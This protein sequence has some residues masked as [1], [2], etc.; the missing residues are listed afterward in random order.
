MNRAPT[1]LTVGSVRRQAGTG[2][3]D[4]VSAVVR[5]IL[6]SAILVRLA[7]GSHPIRPSAATGAIAPN[8]PT[9]IRSR[10]SHPRLIRVLIPQAR[11]SASTISAAAPRVYPCAASHA[12]ALVVTKAAK[13]Q[14][15][16]TA[17][18]R[19]DG[20]NRGSEP[21]L[22]PRRGVARGSVLSLREVANIVLDTSRIF[23]Y[24]HSGPIRVQVASRSA[25]GPIAPR[26]RSK[27]ASKPSRASR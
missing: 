11:T 23:H 5:F 3:A 12:P 18:H 8:A 22:P 21:G 14:W 27:I 1:A 19:Q 15:A 4:F 20:Y 9:R 16:G 25:I 24:I 13:K 26:A 6:S 2:S 7:P 10:L 17:D